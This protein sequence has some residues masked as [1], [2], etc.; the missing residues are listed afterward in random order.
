MEIVV[1]LVSKLGL[2]SLIQVRPTRLT[3]HASMV[4]F[5]NKPLVTSL[6]SYSSTQLRKYSTKMSHSPER[7][8]STGGL[9]PIQVREECVV[10]EGPSYHDASVS[11]YTAWIREEIV[12]VPEGWCASDFAIANERPQRSF[13]IYDTTPRAAEDLER[14]ENLAREFQIELGREHGVGGRD[15]TARIDVWGMPMPMPFA[16]DEDGD[17]GEERKIEVCK[18]HLLAEVAARERVGD[19]GFLVSEFEGC[20]EWRRF[21]LIMDRQGDF[22]DW[23][24]GEERAFLAVY[25]GYREGLET[26]TQRCSWKE[27]GVLL[28]DLTNFF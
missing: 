22:W 15:Q 13:Q 10:E 1:R 25:W 19:E 16:A 2:A 14:L 26:R 12:K 21:L 11:C 3:R 23:D 24:G 27:A 28:E 20:G 9:P 6:S 4:Y 7:R 17:G 18:K 5:I 8:L